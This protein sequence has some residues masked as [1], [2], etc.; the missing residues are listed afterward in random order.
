MPFEGPFPRQEKN[1]SPEIEGYVREIQEYIK[2]NED[3]F[4]RLGIYLPELPEEVFQDV[5]R[6]IS[7][8]GFNIEKVIEYRLDL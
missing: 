4:A 8:K 6:E 1:I 5:K 2:L 7:D 3:D